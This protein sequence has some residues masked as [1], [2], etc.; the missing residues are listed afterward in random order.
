[1]VDASDPRHEEQ[2]AAV[3]RILGSL[4]LSEKP[5]VL[6]FNKADRLGPGEGSAL[7]RSHRDAAA[8]SASTRQGLPE[9]LLRCERLL[10]AEGRVALGDVAV[11]EAGAVA[12]PAAAAP[13][14]LRVPANAGS[15]ESWTGSDDG[16]G[17]GGPVAP[18]ADAPGPRLLPATVRRVS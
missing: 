13:A 14:G 18:P 8:V 9:L 3:E 6:V 16:D 17:A 7:A 12:D 4:G 10:W 2:I 15:R 1:M 11:D 5:R